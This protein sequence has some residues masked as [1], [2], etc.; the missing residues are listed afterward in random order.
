MNI[1]KQT[2]RGEMRSR[3]MTALRRTFPE[4]SVYFTSMQGNCLQANVDGNICFIAKQTEKGATYQVKA[5][6]L[7]GNVNF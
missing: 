4:A 1:D 3:L 6:N 2:P 5:L 7:M